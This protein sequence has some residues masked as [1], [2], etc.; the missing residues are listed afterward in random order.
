[1]SPALTPVFQTDERAIL[2]HNHLSL[3]RGTN[4][5]RNAFLGAIRRDQPY[6]CYIKRMVR[7]RHTHSHT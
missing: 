5:I 4:E 3:C 2:V 6:V 7:I 1:M